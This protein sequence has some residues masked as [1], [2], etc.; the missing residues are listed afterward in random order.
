M[1]GMLRS[2]PST[3]IDLSSSSLMSLWFCFWVLNSLPSKTWQLSVEGALFFLMD[4]FPAFVSSLFFFLSPLQSRLGPLHPRSCWA[5]GPPT[6]SFSWMPT[7]SSGTDPLSW[8]KWSTA[9][10][11]GPGRKPTLSTHPLTSSGTWT[12]TPNTRFG[13]YSPDQEKGGLDNQGHRS[14]LGPSVP[15]SS[16]VEKWTNPHGDLFNG[17]ITQRACWFCWTCSRTEGCSGHA[18][19]PKIFGPLR[20][21]HVPCFAWSLSVLLFDDPGR[22]G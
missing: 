18:Q 19:D 14:S 1:P 6:C 7:P 10:R 8:K 15:V 13:S 11:R 12:P 16:A 20:I 4:F 21:C 17:V 2:I 22:A 9:W 5:W 3:E